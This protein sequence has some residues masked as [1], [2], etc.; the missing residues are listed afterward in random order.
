VTIKNTGTAAVSQWKLGFVFPGTEKI[1][2]G[3]SA[4]YHQSD[5]AVLAHPVGYDLT[6]APG[7][8][9][10]IGYTASYSGTNSAP[11]WYQLDGVRC[12]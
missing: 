11:A 10:T 6:L 7:A 3:W 12:G 9:A 1:T 4:T 5:K 2:Y 8:S